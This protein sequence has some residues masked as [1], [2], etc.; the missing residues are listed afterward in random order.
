VEFRVGSPVF[1]TAD[2]ATWVLLPSAVG[3][4]IPYWSYTE[5]NYAAG[6]LGHL[7][8]LPGQGAGGTLVTKAF[9]PVCAQ[10]LSGGRHL[11]TNSRG[12]IEDLTHPN[13]PTA[14]DSP[15]FATPPS[16]GAEVFE[17]ETQY[18]PTAPNDPSTQTHIIDVH[19]VIPDP[20]LEDWT[21]PIN[22]PSFAQRCQESLPPVRP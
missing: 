8:T 5:A 22:Q 7:W 18:D 9:A 14:T 15:T 11:I 4:A 17:V 13:L 16:L 1:D 6:P 12:V 20:W 19:K 2:P 21:D 3:P 10:R